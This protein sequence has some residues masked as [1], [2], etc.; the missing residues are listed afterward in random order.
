MCGSFS[1]EIVQY[2]SSNDVAA[3]NTASI[4][5]DMF[6]HSAKKMY[7]FYKL[8]EVA[9]V[10]TYNLDKMI[11]VNYYPLPEAKRSTQKHRSIGKVYIFL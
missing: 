1:T 8:K 10:V 7:D 11:D 9:K 3:C 6:V 2:S 4:A 5:V